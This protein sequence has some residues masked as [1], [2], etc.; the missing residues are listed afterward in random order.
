MFLGGCPCC[1]KKECWRCYTDGTDYECVGPNA[2]PKDGWT[3]VGE[4]HPDEESCAEECGDTTNCDDRC[5]PTFSKKT[6][7]LVTMNG[8]HS[9]GYLFQAAIPAGFPINEDTGDYYEPGIPY[10]REL[11]VNIDGEVLDDW[12]LEWYYDSYLGVFSYGLL[13]TKYPRVP[14]P[15]PDPN[16][17]SFRGLTRSPVMINIYMVPGFAAEPFAR[18]D[19][20][21]ATARFS[22]LD[23]R[24]DFTYKDWYSNTVPG[25]VSFLFN[26]YGDYLQKANPMVIGSA[27]TYLIAPGDFVVAGVRE[28]ITGG[29]YFIPDVV[30]EAT[31]EPNW[32]TVPPTPYTMIP[33]EDW[34]N[35][36]SVYCKAIR[37]ED[38]PLGWPDEDNG[39]RYGYVGQVYEANIVWPDMLSIGSKCKTYTPT[40]PDSGGRTMTTTTTGPGTHLKN[41]LAA[42]GI[43]AKKGGGCKC[44]DWEVKM[45]RWGSDCRQHM[46]AI[47]DHL[48]SEAKKRNLPFVRRAGEMLVKRAIKRFEK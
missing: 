14:A 48:Q 7:N 17:P 43:H 39:P 10:E 36:N 23:T 35:S 25:P 15:Q 18:T 46:D 16:N 19:Q 47:V 22:F 34:R 42:W 33:M 24:W 5:S 40:T 31:I 9:G 1:G 44:R 26:G 32:G 30:D 45:N 8:P 2:K 6:N 13:P 11:T 29:H 37:T 28:T 27:N 21:T 4:C 3:P 12:I 41:M 20:C 38:D